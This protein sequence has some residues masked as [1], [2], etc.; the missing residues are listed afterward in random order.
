MSSSS[1]SSSSK[2]NN[3]IGNF[4]SSSSGSNVT[5]ENPTLAL[6]V[7]SYSADNG[8]GNSNGNDGS[9]GSLRV[10]TLCLRSRRACAT[11]RVA[12]DLLR[13]KSQFFDQLIAV[14]EE[15]GQQ[16]AAAKQSHTYT[17]T[18]PNSRRK[19]ADGTGQP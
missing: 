6:S 8:N 4:G 1:K 15:E 11:V 16:S 2:S 17:F 14:K 19:E 13:L 12:A 10:V 5:V 3:G 18:P 9:G 7:S